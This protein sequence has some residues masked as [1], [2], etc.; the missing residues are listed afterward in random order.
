MRQEM[1]H[2]ID[3]EYH[4]GKDDGYVIIQK[5]LYISCM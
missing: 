1:Y 2:L 3:V 4:R 5:G